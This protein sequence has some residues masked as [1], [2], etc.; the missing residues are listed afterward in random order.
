MLQFE[1]KHS[2]DI[3]PGKLGENK[4]LV[5]LLASSLHFDVHMVTEIISLFFI[6]LQ[7]L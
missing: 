3:K 1:T 2:N 4:E 7:Y 6:Y 5:G